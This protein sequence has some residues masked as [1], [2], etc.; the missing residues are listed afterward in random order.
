MFTM[1]TAHRTSFKK[2][3]RFCLFLYISMTKGSSIRLVQGILG[4]LGKE[5]VSTVVSMWVGTSKTRVTS[6]LTRNWSICSNLRYYLGSKNSTLSSYWFQQDS[7]V[8]EV[9]LSVGI[10]SHR[11]STIISSTSC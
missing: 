1:E 10:S 3:Q 8:A 4:S 11:E 6:Y 5:K 2:I 9:I 7:T